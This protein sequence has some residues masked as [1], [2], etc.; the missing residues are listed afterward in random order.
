[1]KCLHPRF[2]R[3]VSSEISREGTQSRSRC[4]RGAP[5]SCSDRELRNAIRNRFADRGIRP[6]S[7]QWGPRMSQDRPSIRRTV[8]RTESA[9]PPWDL[10][11]QDVSAASPFAADSTEEPVESCNQVDGRN[12][13]ERAPL[14]TLQCANPDCTEVFKTRRPDQKR[15]CSARCRAEASRLRRAVE[16]RAGIAAIF[17][18]ALD[19]VRRLLDA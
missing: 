17:E 18:E 12:S 19:K 5:R 13:G 9:G 8:A 7:G 4:S 11:T 14:V 10:G 16:L 2:F 1:V 3:E 6:K 15:C